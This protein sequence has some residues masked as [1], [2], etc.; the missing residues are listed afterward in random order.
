MKLKSIKNK[1]HFIIH[2]PAKPQTNM[3]SLL[4]LIALMLPLL[5][6]AQEFKVLGTLN[7]DARE[8]NM[9]ITPNGKYLFFMSVRGGQP[10]STERKKIKKQEFLNTTEIFGYL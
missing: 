6:S 9:S 1:D 4:F 7:S 5:S 10:W 8:T 3:R 2:D